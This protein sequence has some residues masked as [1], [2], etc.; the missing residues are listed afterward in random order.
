MCD[1]IN[2]F[3]TI[4]LKRDRNMANIH[5]LKLLNK[6]RVNNVLTFLCKFNFFCWC[7]IEYFEAYSNY[8]QQTS[9][10]NIL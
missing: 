10:I 5:A 1:F 7:T 6:M 8:K 4:T 9:N 3:S 2:T